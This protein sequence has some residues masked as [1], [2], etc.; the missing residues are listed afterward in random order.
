M[1]I[2]VEVTVFVKEVQPAWTACVWH[3]SDGCLLE[4]CDSPIPTKCKFMCHRNRFTYGSQEYRLLELVH[5]HI[6]QA[7][8]RIISDV[9]QLLCCPP[10]RLGCFPFKVRWSQVGSCHAFAP[11]AVHWR[12]MSLSGPY[13]C[14]GVQRTS[15]TIRQHFAMPAAH[16]GQQ[17]DWAATSTAL[18]GCCCACCLVNGFLEY[19]SARSADH[20]AAVC[21]ESR[22]CGQQQWQV[23]SIL[24]C[25]AGQGHPRTAHPG[26]TVR[27]TI[28]FCIFIMQLSA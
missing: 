8:I 25:A 5:Y 20:K 23:H 3:R 15:R 12:L 19:P 9:L 24:P 1:S 10:L 14:L 2:A 6:P 7:A 21:C 16:H 11:T 17:A 27:E 22:C 18:L 4:S 28:R 26:P 13:V